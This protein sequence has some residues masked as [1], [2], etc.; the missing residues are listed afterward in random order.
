[1]ASDPVQLGLVASLNRPGGNITGVTSLNVEVGPKKLELIRELVP[2]AAVI[3]VLVNPNN[4]EAEIQSRDAE[5]AARKLGLELRIVH[6]RTE[7]DFDAVF[8][9]L[10]KLR[11]G[12]LVIGPDS[13]F[14]TESG[15][16]GAL[17]LQHMVPAISPYREFTAAGGL[18]SYGASIPDAHRQ[19]GVYAGRIL[20]GE[21]PADLPVQQSTKVELVINM[22]TARTLGLT[23]PITLLGRADEV[24][25]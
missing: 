10:V 1:V 9:T 12:A 2:N 18:M 17:T 24:I 13:F 5:A 4:A 20:K 23:L 25:E 6:A 16:L 7:R 8:A 11:A 22:K 15:R 21:R 14:T 3:S 19:V